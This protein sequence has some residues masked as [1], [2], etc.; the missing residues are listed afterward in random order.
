MQAGREI[1]RFVFVSMREQKTW[2]GNARL[3]ALWS[4]IPRLFLPIPAHVTRALPDSSP[5][6]QG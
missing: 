6:I 1:G 2:I 4:R 3:P 5:S